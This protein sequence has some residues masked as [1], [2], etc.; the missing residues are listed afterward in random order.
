MGSLPL[1]LRALEY[2][3]DALDNEPKLS[4]S[5]SLSLDPLPCFAIGSYLFLSGISAPLAGASGALLALLARKPLVS[6]VVLDGSGVA[7]ERRVGTRWAC[8][9]GARLLLRS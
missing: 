9:A 8:D 2:D 6:H 4:R 3:P 7:N 1:L 5:L